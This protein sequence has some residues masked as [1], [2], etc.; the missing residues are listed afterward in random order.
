MARERAGGRDAAFMFVAMQ[1]VIKTVVASC[2]GVFIPQLPFW[3]HEG[4]CF[5]DLLPDVGNNE[6]DGQV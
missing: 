2:A 3:H 1:G 5:P 4:S 6:S